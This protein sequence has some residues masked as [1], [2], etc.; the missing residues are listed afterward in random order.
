MRK[1]L[2]LTM[3]LVL[4][5]LVGSMASAQSL[6]LVA[7]VGIGSLSL[8]VEG[9]DYSGDLQSGLAFQVGALYNVSNSWSVGLLYDRVRN[10][11]KSSPLDPDL[12][13]A[14]AGTNVFVQ[15]HPGGVNSGFAL[16]GG[17]GSYAYSIRATEGSDSV[18]LKFGPAFGYM[19]GGQLKHQLSGNWSLTGSAAYRAANFSSATLSLTGGGHSGSVDFDAD[20]RAS[21]WSVTFGFA[22]DF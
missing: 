16:F 20:A 13:H 2:L 10:V 17:L 8:T 14:L 12:V 7:G 6:S 5:L 4:V 19:L 1:S 18:E 21:G 3:M 11:D 9:E 15:F 22:Y